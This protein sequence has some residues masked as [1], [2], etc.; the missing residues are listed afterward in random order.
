M[1]CY[2]WGTLSGI[3][4]MVFFVDF[5]IFLNKTIKMPGRGQKLQ[6][7]GRLRSKKLSPIPNSRFLIQFSVEIPPKF[8]NSHPE[9]PFHHKKRRFQEFLLFRQQ[10]HYNQVT[11]THPR[12]NRK[13]CE[14]E[15]FRFC[16]ASHPNIVLISTIYR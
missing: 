6:F 10:F 14:E 7:I 5:S 4:M 9:R 8:Q 13:K 12:R 16:G 11:E 3:E 1:K 2:I 15:K